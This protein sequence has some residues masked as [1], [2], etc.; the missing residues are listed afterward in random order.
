MSN[1]ANTEATL[2]GHFKQIYSEKI[3]DLR[4]SGV[5]VLNMVDFI[6]SSKRTGDFYN[7]PISLGYEHGGPT[8]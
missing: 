2:N 6:E 8:V 4:P 1:A 5:K 3:K 7:Q